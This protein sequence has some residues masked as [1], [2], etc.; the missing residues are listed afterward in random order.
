MNFFTDPMNLVLVAF[1]VVSGGL[2]AWPKLTGGS[3]ASG[4]GTLEVTQLINGKNALVV[5]VRD[6]DE[7]S[8]GSITGARNIPAS[9][10]AGRIAEIA[11]YK[12]KPVIVVCQSGQRSAK[13]AAQLKKEGFGEVYNLSGGIAAWQ[14]A[15]LPL[16]L[17]NAKQFAKASSKA[18]TPEASNQASRVKAAPPPTEKAWP[19]RLNR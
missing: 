15:G 19:I 17:S 16:V 10:V 12:A 18:P 8:S 6:P 2:L 4:I 3:R 5:D 11:R 14:Q 7:F 13:I 1:A 9:A